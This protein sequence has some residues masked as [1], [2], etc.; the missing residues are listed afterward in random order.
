VIFFAGKAGRREGCGKEF[1]C[2][3]GGKTGRVREGIY[4]PGRREDGKGAGRNLFAGKAGRREGCGKEF[5]WNDV[6]CREGG[7]TGRMREGIYLPG[8]RKDG[9]ST[10]RNFR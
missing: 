1:I 4:L 3:E 8:R 6:F 10:G 9:K 5:I 7:K 2:W